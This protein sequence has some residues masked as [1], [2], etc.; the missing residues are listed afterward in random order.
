LSIS[1]S[2]TIQAQAKPI[3]LLLPATLSAG[4]LFCFPPAAFHHVPAQMFMHLLPPLPLPS[5]RPSPLPPLAARAPAAAAAAATAKTWVNI[6]EKR[7]LSIVIRK[8]G[9]DCT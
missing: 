1:L 3:L 5:L 7:V 8:K 6:Q 9:M 4:G 2:D